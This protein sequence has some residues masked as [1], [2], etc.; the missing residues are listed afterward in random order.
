VHS[1]RGARSRR[2]ARVGTQ[3]G[4]GDDVAHRSTPRARRRSLIPDIS[5]LPT[6]EIARVFREEYGRIVAVLARHFGDIDLAEEAIQD[7]F[8]VAVERWPVTGRPPSP[9][10]WIIT[11]ARNR[12]IDRLRRDASRG[13]SEGQAT[14]L[15]TADESGEDGAVRDDLLRLIFTC[16]HPALST[17]AQ[18]ALTLRL[19][20]GLTTA[21]IARAF[22][23]PE[24]TM[25]QRLVR[26]KGKIRDA[27]IPYR[28][29]EPE[30]L[31]ARLAAVLAALYLIF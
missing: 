27:R 29:P 19:L 22:L 12:A 20:A 31:P 9:A 23:C 11:T 17:A 8:A 26:A 24:A 2:G 5:E 10:G 14:L 25:A 21:E 18:V 15:A 3:A 4:R 30:D 28:I 6:S 1:D 13:D 7:A 16:C